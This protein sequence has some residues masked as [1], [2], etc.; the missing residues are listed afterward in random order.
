[1]VMKHWE[2]RDT[3][4]QLA[5]KAVEDIVDI[6]GGADKVGEYLGLKDQVSIHEL[7][8][9]HVI[10]FEINGG[11]TARL[12]GDNDHGYDVFFSTVADY[13]QIEV[14]EDVGFNMFDPKDNHTAYLE[15]WI[16]VRFGTFDGVG[17]RTVDPHA[18]LTMFKDWHDLDRISKG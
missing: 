10:L 18:V 9:E 2:K 13:H 17:I 7:T 6:V 4:T 8:E 16:D 11:D 3:F 5:W 12:L 15:E 14:G 1:M